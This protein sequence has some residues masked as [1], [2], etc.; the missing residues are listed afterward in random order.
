MGAVAPI[1]SV[2]GTVAGVV[3]G[4]KAAKQQKKAAQAQVKSQQVNQR[5]A[6]IRAARSRRQQ[7]AQARVQQAQ[8]MAGGFG[9]GIGMG[10]SA[11][12]GSL[13]ASTASTAGNIGFSQQIQGMS[14]QASIFNQQAAT[15]QGN[16]A[17]AG[18][19]S[20]L[21]QQGASIFNGPTFS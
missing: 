12:Q 16:A 1:L 3:Q 8:Q 2:V 6:D 15:A 11:I 17:A 10:S 5:I 7:I 20:N 21:F 9:A 13:A 18:A 4:Q 19:M 14:G